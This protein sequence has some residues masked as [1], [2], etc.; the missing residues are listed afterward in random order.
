MTNQ[1][2]TMRSASSGV[3]GA[4]DDMKLVS[5]QVGR[6]RNV[7][8]RGK[9]VSTGIYK[10]PVAGRIMVH[11]FNLDGDQQADDRSRRTR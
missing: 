5:V 2:I 4:T 3:G 10:E 6:P 7:Q 9:P 11:R 8:W 1:I